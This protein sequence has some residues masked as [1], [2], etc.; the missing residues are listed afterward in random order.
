MGDFLGDGGG[1]DADFVLA[2]FVAAGGVD[3]K[4]NLA[5]FH[6]VDDVRAGLLG[7]FEEAGAGNAFRLE[8]GVG[9]AGG[10]ELET[11]VHQIAGD[12]DRPVF[13]EIRHGEKHVATGGQWVEGGHLRL[14]IGHPPIGVDAHDLAGGF[15]FRA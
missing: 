11:E 10:I 9:A 13:V 6:H 7:E 3:H 12:G 2:G 4:V 8:P 1:P 5:V 15:H 14:G